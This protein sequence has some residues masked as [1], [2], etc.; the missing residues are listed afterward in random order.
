MIE[1][2]VFKFMLAVYNAQTG[3]SVSDRSHVLLTKDNY[4]QFVQG[5]FECFSVFPK[6]P[7]QVIHSWFGQNMNNLESCRGMILRLTCVSV[8]PVIST[9]DELSQ[10][11]KVQFSSLDFKIGTSEEGADFDQLRIVLDQIYSDLPIMYLIEKFQSNQ[12]VDR[13]V[14]YFGVENLPSL[15]AAKFWD[16]FDTEEELVAYMNECTSLTVQRETV[17][18]LQVEE[19]FSSALLDCVTCDFKHEYG[20]LPFSELITVLK[21][22]TGSLNKDLTVKTRYNFNRI[23]FNLISNNPELCPICISLGFRQEH[24]PQECPVKCQLYQSGLLLKKLETASLNYVSYIPIYTDGSYKHPYAGVGV[25]FS[26]GNED[27][28]SRPVVAYCSLDAELLAIT[29]A[30]KIVVQKYPCR[31]Y[32]I[33]TDSMASRN[34]IYGYTKAFPFYRDDIVAEAK[35]YMQIAGGKVRIHFVKSHS[36]VEGNEAADLLAKEGRMMSDKCREDEWWGV[37]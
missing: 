37:N 11:L 20:K 14:K 27:N 33:H 3:K 7:M 2:F 23:F 36:G 22:L 12:V 26:D 29:L 15:N 19:C 28:Q 32:E 24:Q 18:M 13:A 9:A 21:D 34:L 1:L 30:L 17:T 4:R 10:F 5:L 16:L 8:D 6:T 25:F 35:H 31:N